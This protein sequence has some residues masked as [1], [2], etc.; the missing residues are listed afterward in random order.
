MRV[1]DDGLLQSL[2]EGM[3]ETPLWREFLNRLLAK[4][5]AQ[6]ISLVF[7]PVHAD[8][9][10]RLFA[11]AGPSADIISGFAKDHPKMKVTLLSSF[12]RVLKAQFARGECDIILTTE[13]GVDPEG[14]TIAELPLVWVGAPQ[15]AAWKS[16]AWPPRARARISFSPLRCDQ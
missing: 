11:G 15:G 10:V 5:G 2:H 9:D 4:T 16:K 1:D 6:V 12:T 7:R 3:F 8:E 13:A 14:E